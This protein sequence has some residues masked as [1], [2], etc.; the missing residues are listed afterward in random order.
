MQPV[1]AGC[2]ICCVLRTHFFSSDT[3]V[4][5]LCDE[6]RRV[7]NPEPLSFPEYSHWPPKGSRMASQFLA[8]KYPSL[9]S[10]TT[11]RASSLGAPGH[12]LGSSGS[13]YGSRKRCGA[14]PAE[15]SGSLLIPAVLGVATRWH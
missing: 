12:S 11:S 5:G 4:G 6:V 1:D 8:S 10:R 9:K 3:K 15:S 2:S 7:W 14:G 13:Q